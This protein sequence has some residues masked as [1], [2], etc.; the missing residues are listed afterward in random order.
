LAPTATTHAFCADRQRCLTEACIVLRAESGI[1]ED[2]PGAPRLEPTAEL[3][4]HLGSIGHRRVGMIRGRPGLGTTEE[5]I[6]GFRQGLR[7][8]GLRFY[9]DYLVSGNSVDEAAQQALLQLL[10]LPKPPTAIVVGNNRMTIGV[11]RAARDARVRIPDDLAIVSF[12]DFEW[13][14][15]FHPSLTAIAQPTQAM[16]EQALQLVLTRLADPSMP[17]RRVVMRP[18]LVHRDSCGCAPRARP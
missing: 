1:E 6:A 10:S 13:A 17:T 5:R 7:R 8:N 12:D 2:Q 18:T 9:S 15:L 14:D 3:V 4:D 11:M 16:G